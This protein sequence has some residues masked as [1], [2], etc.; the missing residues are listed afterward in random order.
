MRNLGEIGVWRG[1]DKSFAQA[2][3]AFLVIA[4]I[5]DGFVA[6]ATSKTAKG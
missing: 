6:R 3:S 1:L 4:K 2:K 5:P